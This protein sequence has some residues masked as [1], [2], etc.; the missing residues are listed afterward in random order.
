MQ[1]VALQFSILNIPTQSS[2]LSPSFDLDSL[3]RYLSR[4]NESHQQEEGLEIDNTEVARVLQQIA[5]MLEFKNEN[6]FKFRSYQ[7]AAETIGSMA[8]PITD[9]VSRGG[10]DELQKIPGIGKTISMQILEI[11]RTGRSSYFEELIRDVPA[12]VLDLR[13]V[14]GIGLKT[15]Q[16]LYRDFGINSLDQLK[17]FAEGGGLASVPGL[18]EKTVSRVKSSLSRLSE[19]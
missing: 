3:G 12:T 19:K 4:V 1:D 18:G 10:A 14:S 7:M 6:P 13:R 8:T 5:D 16:L 9:I 11:L 15:A 17:S 2:V